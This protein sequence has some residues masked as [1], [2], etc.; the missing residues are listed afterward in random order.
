MEYLEAIRRSVRGLVS[1]PNVRFSDIED[2]FLMI[3]YKDLD[4]YRMRG[5]VP[6]GQYR[7]KGNV[8]R[9]L[10]LALIKSQSGFELRDMR[11]EGFTDRHNIDLGFYLNGVLYVAGQVKM[12]GSPAHRLPSGEFKPERTTRAD[13]DKRIKEVKYTPID[14][15]LKYSGVNIGNWEEWV[16]SS[17][18]TFYSFWGCRIASRDNIDLIIEKFLGLKK[19]NSGV[20]VLLYREERGRY[21]PI[22]DPRLEELDIDRAVEEMGKFLLEKIRQ[23][24]ETE[25]PYT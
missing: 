6:E 8:F 23:P 11:V 12:L 7:Q 9:D 1:R 17:I 10:I 13:I 21:V 14:L 3:L 4:K 5:L 16:R 2:E 20:G 19:Y 24:T 15:K 25:L 18:P 22:M